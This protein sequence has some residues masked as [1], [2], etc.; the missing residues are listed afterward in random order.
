MTLLS[1]MMSSIL[2]SMLT[3]LSKE[4]NLLK[5]E[6][7]N[8]ECGFQSQTEKNNQMS[9][10]FF[11]IAILFLIFD[12]EIAFILPIPLSET[13]FNLNNWNILIILIILLTG[14]LAEWKMGMIEWTK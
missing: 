3:T 7:S 2:Y 13:M 12:V 10:Q 4:K 8:F 6:S 11:M 14:T 9:S 5:E 1:V